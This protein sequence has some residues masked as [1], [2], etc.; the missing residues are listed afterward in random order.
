[1]PC[2]PPP[3]HSSIGMLLWQ[4]L[5]VELELGFRGRAGFRARAGNVVLGQVF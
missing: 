5:D 3:A 4:E 2:A 1:M